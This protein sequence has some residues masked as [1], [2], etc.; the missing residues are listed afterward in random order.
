MKV[1]VSSKDRK[2]RYKD[3]YRK[4]ADLVKAFMSEGGGPDC[5]KTEGLSDK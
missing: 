4:K 1:Q 2:G 3:A 5:V